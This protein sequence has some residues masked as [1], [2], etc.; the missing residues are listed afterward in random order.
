MS[1][2]FLDLPVELLEE[3]Y[4]LLDGKA[5]QNVRL[6]SSACAKINQRA[7]A[8]IYFPQ[9]DIVFSCRNSLERALGILNHPGFGARVRKIAVYLDRYY[10]SGDAREAYSTYETSRQD[11]QQRGL[12]QTLLWQIFQQARALNKLHDVKIE[13]A[14][15]AVY[16]ARGQNAAG[17]IEPDITSST[18]FLK[19]LNII[20]KSDLNSKF[21]GTTIAKGTSWSLPVHE[22]MKSYRFRDDFYRAL[23]H[24]T[25]LS[26]DIWTDLDEEDSWN[27]C[28]Y[29]FRLVAGAPHLRH[30]AIK[31]RNELDPTLDDLPE[32]REVDTE[33]PGT[34]ILSQ[35][36]PALQ[37]LELRFLD[38]RLAELVGFLKRHSRVARVELVCVEIEGL[39]YD[40]EMDGSMRIQLA[41]DLAK[42]SN[43]QVQ[44][45]DVDCWSNLYTL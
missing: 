16:R 29:F 38:I 34:E 2:G 31:S 39:G 27:P 21:S 28:R 6:V 20:S 23:K 42:V 13:T 18:D 44:V 25:S 7:F 33:A 36:F 15:D 19:V 41:M 40:D 12:D 26:L 10:E 30:L 22:S 37:S 5:L 4:S 32:D 35:T 1:T 3:F 14:Y 8:D 9:L 43:R 11:L 45:F 17:Y 24:T